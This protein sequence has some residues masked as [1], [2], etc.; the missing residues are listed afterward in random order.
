ERVADDADV[1]ARLEGERRCQLGGLFGCARRTRGVRPG[2]IKDGK[3]GGG[4]QQGRG[5]AKSGASAGHGESPGQ[6]GGRCG[7]GSLYEPIWRTAP[8]QRAEGGSRHP[9]SCRSKASQSGWSVNTSR[10]LS[11]RYA[12]GVT[13]MAVPARFTATHSSST[14]KTPLSRDTPAAVP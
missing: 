9:T 11:R 13:L 14:W 10:R 4:R 2:G 7:C 3:Q 6:M 12:V 5:G 1:V 8:R